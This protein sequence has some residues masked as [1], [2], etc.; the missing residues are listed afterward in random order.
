M[1]Y[2]PNQEKKRLFNL[3][4]AGFGSRN[5]LRALVLILCISPFSLAAQE[6]CFNGIDDDGD[7]LIDVFDPDCP[8]DDQTL[9][10]KPS[11]EFAIPG[12]ALNFKAQWTSVDEVPIYQ[13]PLVADMDADGVPDVIIMSSD[14]LKSGDPRRARNILIISGAT[15]QTITK[16]ITPYMAWVGPNPYAV[17][18]IDSDGFGEIIIATAD[19]T[20][21]PASER[22]YLY[23]YEHTGALKW[24][25][26]SQYG[27]GSTARF[28][29]SVGLADFNRDGIPE[30]YVYNQIFNALTGR[31]VIDGGAGN[32]YSIMT[33]QAFGDLAN[34][35]AADI[36]SSPGLELACGNTVYNVVLTNNGGLPGNSMTPI[37]IS[38][39]PDGYTSLADIDLDGKMDVV[40]AA[41]GAVGKLYVWNPNEG[42]PVLIASINLPNTG[43]NWIG[44][45]FIGD[46]D[47]DCAPEIGVTRASRVYALEYDGTSTLAQKWTLPTT[48]ASGFTGITMFDFNQD[49]KQE[50]VY[51]DES[52]LR[53]IDGSGSVPTVIGSNPCA[54]GT[55]S[56]MPVVADV[57]GDGQAEICVTCATT[58]I[59]YGRVNVFESSGQMWA[60][61]RPIWNQFNYFNVNI[62]TSLTIPRQQQPHQVLLST[63]ACPFYT[64]TD[65]RPF[66]SFMA[67][68]TFLTQ[69]GCPIYPA[70]DVNLEILSQQCVGS[71]QINLV[72]RVSNDGGSPSDSAYPIRFYAGNPFTGP[73]TLLTTNPANIA[74]SGPLNPGES[75][76]IPL[77]LDI[78]N[79]PKPFRLTVLL[80][81]DGSKAVPFNFPVTN[82]PECDYLDNI[83]VIAALD[84]CPS[85]DLAISGFTPPV[86]AFCNGTSSQIQVSASSTV[87]IDSTG[88]TWHL[89]DNSTRAGQSISVTSG[90]KYSVEVKDSAHCVARDSIQVSEIPQPTLASA[91]SDQTLCS[92]NAVLQGNVPNV[93]IG[94]W[95][96]IEGGATLSNPALPNSGVS[97]L[98]PGINRFKWTITSGGVCVSEDT[99]SIFRDVAPSSADAG[100]D[101]GVCAD[102]SSLNAVE[103]LI[104]TGRWTRISG[105]GT[106][107]DSLLHSTAV[108]GLG[109]GVNVFRWTVSNGVCPDKTDD[110]S[111]TRYAP[112]SLA[113]AGPNQVVCSS[114]ANLAAELPSIGNGVWTLV[115][116]S[117]SFTDSTAHNTGVTGLAAGDNV[118]RW[119]VSNGTCAASTDE[120]IVSRNESPSASNAGNNQQ[121][122]T[123]A[124]ALGASVPL[125]GSGVWSLLS[126][127]AI[128]ADTLNPNS[129]LSSISYG[130]HVLAWTVRNGVC[131]PS[132]SQVSVRR[133]E[134][135]SPADAGPDQ[136]FCADS[137]TLS[138][139][140]PA[141][142]TGTWSFL[143]GSGTIV[144]P[145]SATSKVSGLSPGN[146]VLQWEI[147]NGTCPA[148][149]ST[150]NLQVDAPV[151]PV[152]AGSDIALCTDST[153]LSA[154]PPIAGSGLWQLVSGSATLSNPSDPNSALVGIAPG[155]TVLRWKVNNGTCSD[156]DLV[157]V[158]R[159]LPP[160]PA[161]AG[162]DQLICAT[163]ASLDANQPSSGTGTWS[164][165]SGSATFGNPS[166]PKD[167]VNNLSNGD[168]L[169]VWTIRSGV[170]QP[171]TDTVLIRVS[172][173]P[174]VPNAGRDTAICAESIALNAVQPQIGAGSWSLV[175]GSAVIADTLNAQTLVSNLGPGSQ[176]FRW[177]VV[178]GAC[179]AFDLVT[180]TRDTPPSAALAGP[181]QSVCTDTARLA[182]NLPGN[183]IGSWHLGSGSGMLDDSLDNNTLIRN[184]QPGTYQLNWT[185]RSGVCLPTSDQMSLEV[186]ARPSTPDAGADQTICADTL[187]LNASVPLI[188]TGVWKT[189]SG[190]AILDDTSDAKTI[191][192]GLTPGVHVLQWTVGNGICPSLSDQITISRDVPP[193]PANAG[194]DQQIC[195]DT[196]RME[197]TSPMNGTG[198][199][200][201]VSGNGVFLDPSS[202]TSLVNN[203]GQGINVF[204][205]NVHNGSCPPSTD[206]VVIIHDSAAVMANAGADI[207][208]C[209]SDTV[210]LHAQDPYP[211]SGYWSLVSGTAVFADST[212][213]STFVSGLGGQSAV[214]RWTVL[215]ASCPGSSDEMQVMNNQAPDTAFAGRDT[216]LCGTAFKLNAR[217]PLVGTG[218]WQVISG[219][220]VLDNENLAQAQIS[221][222]SPGTNLLSWTVRNGNCPPS[223]DTLRIQVDENP[224]NPNAGADQAL[225]ADSTRLSAAIPAIG[226]GVWSLV[227]GAGMLADSSSA[228][229][230]LSQLGPGLNVFR[231]TVS[232]G[233]CSVFDEVTIQRDLPPDPA[234]AG[235]DQIVCDSVVRLAANY[236]ATGTGLW[237]VV[238]GNGN[239]D[240]LSNPNAL[241]SGLQVGSI[242]LK[243]T[244]KNG[245]CPDTADLVTITRQAGPTPAQ[246]GTDLTVCLDTVRLAAT[247]VQHGWG[248]WS[249]VS[250]NGSIDS[251]NHPQ[252]VVRGLLPGIL[253]LRWTVA[254]SGSCPG[255]FDEV[256]ILHDTPPDPAVLGGDTALCGNSIELT[257]NIPTNGTGHWIVVGGNATVS[258]SSSN[259]AVFSNLSQG[260]NVFEWR[261]RSGS[262]T[263]AT[264]QITVF[265]SDTANAGSNHIICDSVATLD[266]TAALSGS[267]YWRV[268]S[269]SAVLAD[270]SLENTTVT[271]LSE[272][273]NRFV[274]TISGSLCSDTT[275]TVSV[276]RRCNIPPVIRN[277]SFTIDEDQT[278]IDSLITGADFD[279]DSTALQADTIPISGPSHG[280][281]HLKPDGSFSYKPDTNYYGP[282]TVVVRICDTGIPLP[283]L[284]GLDT[285]VLQ[286]NPVN[287]KPVI[288]SDTF[289]IPV[290][291]VL[292]GNILANGDADPDSTQLVVDTIPLVGP[293]HGTIS[294]D[295][296]GNFTYIPDSSF[297][298]RDTVLIE[299]CDQGFPL[300]PLCATDT[301]IIHVKPKPN[302][303]PVVTPDSLVVLEDQSGSSSLLIGDFDPDGTTLTADT[304]PLSGP[305]HG[306]IRIQPD[307][308]YTYTPEPDYYGYDTVIVAVCD[309][310]FPLP[311]ACSPDTLIIRIDPVNDPPHIVNDTA[312]TTSGAPISGNIL[313]NDS[314]KETALRVD[315]I[316][317]SGPSHGMLILHPDGSYAYTPDP[318]FIGFDTVIVQV[319]DSGYPLPPICLPDTLFI[320][321]RDTALVKADA[322]S[323]QEICLL[324]AQL[325]AEAIN[326]PA[327]GIWS[328]I[329]GGGILGDSS[330]AS[331]TVS[332]LSIGANRFVW[333]AHNGPKISTDTVLITVK[334]PPT[335]AFAGEDQL[336]CGNSTEV[337]GNV[338]VH[339]SG[340][341]SLISGS[342]SIS[343]PGDAQTL[344]GGL[345]QGVNRLAWTIVNETCVSSDTLSIE[346]FTAPVISAGTDTSI[347]PNG[348]PFA[349]QA[350]LGG[351]T[352]GT[353]SV[354]LGAAVVDHP[355]DPHSTVSGL[356]SGLNVLLFS[357][358]NGPCHASDSLRITVLNGD[359]LPCKQEE[360]FIPE[361]FSPDEDGTN[362]KLVIYGLNGRRM[363]ILVF[364]R[365][366][367]LVY[368]SNPYLNN[369]D[370]VCNQPNVISGDYLPEGTYFYIIQIEGES[371]TRKGYLT[372]WR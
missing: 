320:V 131:P 289:T 261:I 42:S 308:S 36:T 148:S 328:V 319:C 110:V 28:G 324:T 5:F 96:V 132:V 219:N 323:D 341:W 101:L 237:T 272:G 199:W 169:L 260:N 288:H 318:D 117:G 366:G 88:Y 191:V 214:F 22:R 334:Q 47:K 174:V 216:I 300:P 62:N 348:E 160:S 82:L 329:E 350:E 287:D 161:S 357:A 254:D 299:V 48:D 223:T 12:G 137:T 93:G 111:I 326:P 120:V 116:G 157:V 279:P 208:L 280:S 218:Q 220:G 56:E 149:V 163:S 281:I 41:E 20:D 275:D 86:L 61:C 213:A 332:S 317:L 77:S 311:P 244:I 294:L 103:P 327:Y 128:I 84:C 200:T 106:L 125:I 153:L 107:A 353:W 295:S 16:I 248:T 130:T 372:L 1:E 259:Q 298:G 15:G 99:V 24:K 252:S 363:S 33:H 297:A 31:K 367:T 135:P 206:Q 90:G 333:T 65:N 215:P 255:S 241:L 175:S 68:S 284:C 53:I 55:G 358:Q 7:N 212:S 45:P 79:F 240:T 151:S 89:P 292:T 112:P 342:G 301:L 247:P 184:L 44:V 197:A 369:W 230:A 310:G 211:A 6:N 156:S 143:S 78:L 264:D 127:S 276:F 159:A 196:V 19:H 11:C 253:V 236:P 365:W 195:S 167:Q 368:E 27:N 118:F 23:C 257:A 114:Q 49:G 273:E 176:V 134:M 271:G 74:T 32:G 291:S 265:R 337:Q 9:I 13:T 209:A 226:T 75:I 224:L 246:A 262:C 70:S 180:I 268:L 67:Q 50:L 352:S 141:I 235:A 203:L 205:W 187:V 171:E 76:D 343:Q 371:E 290:D 2:I 37:Q 370:G 92:E 312:E 179:R 182:A 152:H 251:I 345:Q 178:N 43:G 85:G 245:T 121:I 30:V 58:G 313:S 217:A 349:L 210:S 193:D 115:S 325:N 227:S 165:A 173:N 249:I 201:V 87:G 233:L 335:P 322:G 51:R 362:D 105:S 102:A 69:A 155:N 3:P 113:N 145:A 126:G 344:I 330:L 232:N 243:W 354:L 269:G 278:L 293:S 64:C 321:I 307:G 140:T 162:P 25:S 188:G 164:A 168:N 316:P 234:M 172:E 314:D 170:C 309:S 228:G 231:W 364:N 338:P 129:A 54:S 347:C 38:G 274:W 39:Q 277:D 71:G 351:N 18:D 346:V 185:I 361:G 221:N 242:T 136:Q 150:L 52:T 263:P 66:N 57:D 190:S 186:L 331:T 154:N 229:S 258:D 80:N 304:I 98:S 73:A 109:I 177:T 359:S 91:G 46:M 286:I 10:C 119:T 360:I 283:P 63:T 303:P 305:S 181:D 239:I 204:Q 225:C 14:S 100:A 29:S 198:T 356:A 97:N 40:V 108:S 4:F 17:A 158:T 282:D 72:L 81:D 336:V 306:T 302:P 266:A 183:G 34:P 95:T 124:T 122:C 355:D 285:L 194:A 146:Y 35:V 192:R 104:G 340:T 256:R 59:Q 202:P 83:E 238:S 296:S 166:D 94:N 139:S 8:C 250:G 142:G 315:S 207:Q 138:G 123:D 21:N 222:L 267:G 144:N 270:S 147:R 60:P 133:D 26:N 339:G 189:I